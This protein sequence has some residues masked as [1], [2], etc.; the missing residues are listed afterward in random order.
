LQH[1]RI[2]EWL[3]T[4]CWWFQ[5]FFC[6]III[7]AGPVRASGPDYTLLPFGGLPF[8]F[9]IPF[10]TGLAGNLIK[11]IGMQNLHLFISVI[12]AVIIVLIATQLFGR[13]FTFLK[14]PRVVGE[15][16]AGVFLGPTV[17]GY[18][19]PAVSE[20]VFSPAV[21]P[22]LFV[23]SNFGLSIYMFI[24]GMEVDSHKVEKKLLRHT[25]L[26]SLAT[27]IV[28]F[29]LGLGYGLVYFDLF[30]GANAHTLDFCIFVGSALAITA[31][32]MLAR[33]LQENNLVKTKLGTISLL[34]ASI[35]DVV[36]WI[37]LSYVTAAAT[38]AGGSKTVVTIALAFAFFGVMFFAVK[39]LLKRML[40]KVDMNKPQSV[41]NYLSVVLV[42]LLANALITDAI[43]LY[44][45]F[46]G[47][48]T[49]LIVPRNKELVDHITARIKDFTVILLLPLFFA[50][51]GLN[52]NMLVL[53]KMSF[54]VP[55][56]IA[57]V[58]AF[59]G[60]YLSTLFSMKS[61]GYNWK[62]SS[63]IGGLIN[64]RGLMELIIANLGLMYGVISA[65]LYSILVLIA[66]LSTL[67]AMPIYRL[68][69]IKPEAPEV[70]EMK[71]NKPVISTVRKQVVAEEEMEMAV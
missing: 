22:F 41:Q 42:L 50:F 62:E 14:Q 65:E 66:V 10:S 25:M 48:V 55:M 30:K 40:K 31:F 24:V 38:H 27:I 35:Q 46:G 61:M 7:F 53:G 60:K 23:L 33:I 59:A 44:S 2:T 19:F 69:K 9:K 6:A 34:S 70:P 54:F 16:F 67:C 36:S 21:K 51:S 64:A 47:F 29:A 4:T 45:V 12:I 13:L 52:A 28:P 68:S 1:K 63:A 49:G 20:S 43:G 11:K 8:S 17:I 3:I 32:P 37:L 57:V 39:P 58:L 5:P 56:L 26:L 71:V 15:M 18:F